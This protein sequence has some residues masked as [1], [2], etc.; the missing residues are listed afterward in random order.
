MSFVVDKSLPF[1][2][3]TEHSKLCHTS[4]TCFLKNCP[5][6]K[7]Y[8]HWLFA[9]PRLASPNCS[10]QTA[11]CG[12]EFTT[13]SLRVLWAYMRF[14]WKINTHRYLY[15]HTH[16]HTNIY[17]HICTYIDTYIHVSDESNLRNWSSEVSVANALFDFIDSNADIHTNIHAFAWFL[18]HRSHSN[19]LLHT[20]NH[21]V[22]IGMRRYKLTAS[23][24][25]PSIWFRILSNIYLFYEIF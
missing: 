18:A 5:I 6:T 2:S 19:L 17:T 25:R 24:L 11:E 4:H 14:I 12:L 20:Y 10:T 9:L 22:F 3:F 7:N 21:W 15:A 13:S 8:Y 1:F 16:T 23:T